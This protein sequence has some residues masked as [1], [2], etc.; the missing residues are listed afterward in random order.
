MELSTRQRAFAAHL[1]DPDKM[2]PPEG[3]EDRRL[4]VYRDLFINNIT[5][6]LGGAFPVARRV[7]GDAGWQVLIREFYSSHKAHTPYFLEVPREFVEWL[8]LRPTA[9]DEPPFLVELAHYEWVELA[10][11]VSDAELPAAGIDPTGD[12]M[13]GHPVISPLAWPLAYHWPVQQIGP[14]Y[15][16]DSAP[17]QPTFLVVYRDASDKVRFLEASA[18]TA[19][20]LDAIEQDATLSGRPGPDPPAG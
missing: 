11:A 14:D 3:I 20:L 19:A 10:L 15:L 12:L 6:L 18:M 2:P 1:R 16:P 7:L 4:A 8:T 9:G 5:E 17:T 13:Q